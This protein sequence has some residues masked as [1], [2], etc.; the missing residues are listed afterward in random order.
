MWWVGWAVGVVASAS[1]VTCHYKQDIHNYKCGGADQLMCGGWECGEGWVRAVGWYLYTGRSEESSRASAPG[2][3]G[4]QQLQRASSFSCTPGHDQSDVFYLDAHHLADARPRAAESR[5]GARVAASSGGHVLD[6][7][8]AAGGAVSGAQ[9]PRR[10]RNA[11]WDRP[12]ADWRV[13][14]GWRV[15]WD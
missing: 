15:A 5:A 3:S 6:R 4:C 2:R 14:W 7:S 9:H 10:Q 12:A 8:S 11:A 13:V 1:Y